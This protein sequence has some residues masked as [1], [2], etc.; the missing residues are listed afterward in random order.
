MKQFDVIDK[1]SRIK[2]PGI[3]SL[4][5]DGRLFEEI[6]RPMPGHPD[7]IDY[8]LSEVDLERYE[9]IGRDQ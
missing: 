7:I 2:R 6:P 9:I 5:N 1:K 4:R 3:F 8:W